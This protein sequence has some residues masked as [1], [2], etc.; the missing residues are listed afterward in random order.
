MFRSPAHHHGDEHE[1]RHEANERRPT[2]CHA[3]DAD[4]SVDETG[5]YRVERLRQIES[6]SA[7]RP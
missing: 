7:G 2:R 5:K 6:V 4:D 3:T 1:R